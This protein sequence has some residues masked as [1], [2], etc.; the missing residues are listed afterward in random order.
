MNQVN[1]WLVVF[2]RDVS[3]LPWIRLNGAGEPDGQCGEV[4]PQTLA[5]LCEQFAH[6]AVCL[7]IPTADVAFHRVR[8]PGKHNAVGMRALPWLLEEKLGVVAPGL[9]TVALASEGEDVWAAAVSAERLSAWQAPFIAAGIQLAKIVPDALA[10]PWHEDT[11][12]ALYRE[13]G[14]LLRTGQ[15]QGVEVD[16]QWLHVWYDAWQRERPQAVV[17]CYGERP[18]GTCGWE[19]QPE[20]DPLALLA[21]EAVRNRCSLI[22]EITGQRQ[23]I[24]RQPLYAVLAV[25]ALLFI[26]KG[27]QWWQQMQRSDVLY[28]QVHTLF[29]QRF[30]GQSTDNWQTIVAR[31]TGGLPGQRFAAWLSVMPALPAGVTVNQ[32]RY[33]AGAEQL[34]ITL[35]GNTPALAQA[36]QIL[37]Q[38]FTVAPQPDGSINLTRREAK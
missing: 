29:M 5:G 11:P 15:W 16:S 25:L 18:P 32:L 22:P 28:Q 1:G 19:V 35:I 7:L 4:T 13:N 17:R 30:P 10:L 36:T 34:Q 33:R 27:L 26:Y 20:Q 23:S 38:A 2:W 21:G 31:S 6:E 24:W 8:L 37:S 14:W 9:Y 12:V 3:S